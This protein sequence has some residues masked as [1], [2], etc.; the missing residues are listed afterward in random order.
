MCNFDCEHQRQV[1][2]DFCHSKVDKH[3][4]W[5]SN[6]QVSLVQSLA[7]ALLEVQAVSVIVWCF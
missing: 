6:S 4:L 1:C 2:M 7:A 5:Q 3:Q